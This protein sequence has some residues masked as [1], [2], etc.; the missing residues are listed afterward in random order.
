VI[1]CD[2]LQGK[3]VTETINWRKDKS[4]LKILINRLSEME[5]LSISSAKWKTVSIW[6]MVKGVKIEPESFRK[7][8]PTFDSNKI[9]SIL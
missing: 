6:F 4:S 3:A 9:L 1:L 5:Y 7:L 2:I 8:H